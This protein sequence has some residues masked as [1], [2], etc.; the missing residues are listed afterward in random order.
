MASQNTPFRSTASLMLGISLLIFILGAGTCFILQN[1]FGVNPFHD[2]HQG[3]NASASNLAN[4]YYWQYILMGSINYV[5]CSLSLLGFRSLFRSKRGWTYSIFVVLIWTVLCI[6]CGFMLWEYQN[7]THILN[8]AERDWGKII[9]M[10]SSNLVQGLEV[11]MKS[12]PVN[13]LGLFVVIALTTLVYKRLK[14]YYYP[15]LGEEKVT[16]RTRSGAVL[17]LF[18]KVFIFILVVGSL[19]TVT[20]DKGFGILPFHNQYVDRLIVDEGTSFAE[21]FSLSITPRIID[22]PNYA[23]ES[24]LHYIFMAAV[25]YILSLA[26]LL[27]ISFFYKCSLG[28]L[29]SSIIVL[30]WGI[31]CIA[32][33]CM[34]WDYQMQMAT[35]ETVD[36][37]KVMESA[38][39]ATSSGLKV[40]WK[41]FP[42]NLIGFLVAF[43]ATYWVYKQLKVLMNIEEDRGLEEHLV[44]MD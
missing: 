35:T 38:T 44:E 5:L 4:E 19:T 34:L 7:Q 2:P 28:V 13:L 31:F 3:N 14:S 15:N 22:V 36:W 42:I 27:P 12:F 20:L 29:Y 33:G 24:Y 26:I 40:A 17:G 23:N 16:T 6:S 25:L 43:G 37:G 18:F 1:L 21:G 30:L 39:F 11:A 9:G 8:L 41:S 10:G 32:G